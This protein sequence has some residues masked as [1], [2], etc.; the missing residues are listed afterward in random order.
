MDGAVSAKRT[1][2]KEYELTPGVYI[3]YV[4]MFF[5][6]NYEKEFDI[7]LA[8]YAEYFCDIEL[9]SHSDAVAFTGNQSV[10]W[11]GNVEEEK[12]PWNSLGNT[13]WN[14]GNQ[15]NSGWGNQGGNNGWGN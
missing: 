4:K 2:Y 14:G 12:K 8:V 1:L 10:D 9:A 5:D 7:N 13:T 3:A 6:K 11:S 15:G